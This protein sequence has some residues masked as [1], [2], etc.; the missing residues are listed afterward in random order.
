MEGD[1]YAVLTG[2]TSGIIGDDVENLVEEFKRKDI[3]IVYVE[4]S[5]F[6]GDSYFGYEASLTELVKQFT[7]E[8]MKKM[9]KQLIFLE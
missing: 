7:E 9:I 6:K 8:S 3:P 5:G 2:C 1:L 4:T